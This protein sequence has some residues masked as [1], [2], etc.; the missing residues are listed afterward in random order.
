MNKERV[1]LVLELTFLIKNQRVG[2]WKR[3]NRRGWSFLLEI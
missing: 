1:E 2:C 3:W